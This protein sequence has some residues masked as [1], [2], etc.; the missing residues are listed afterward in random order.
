MD[1]Q[2]SLKAPACQKYPDP[3]PQRDENGAESVQSAINCG[4]PRR[5]A[6]SVTEGAPAGV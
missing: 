4:A 3:V 2:L 5:M 6:K 1:F